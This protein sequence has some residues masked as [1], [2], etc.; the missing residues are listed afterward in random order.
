M[1]HS[2]SENS[3]EARRRMASPVHRSSRERSEPFSLEKKN[4]KKEKINKKPEKI[5]KKVFIEIKNVF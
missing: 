1:T 4:K 3:S 2:P 5:N